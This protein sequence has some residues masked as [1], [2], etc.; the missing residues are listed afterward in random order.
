MDRALKEIRTADPAAIIFLY[1]DHGPWTSR[2]VKFANDN[3]FFVEDRFGTLGAVINADRCLPFLAPPPGEHFQTIA[4]TVVGL[5]QCLA[6]G[7]SPLTQSV[8]YGAIRQVGQGAKFE[9]YIYE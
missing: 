7:T 2:Q 8:D 5:V 9:D 3:K 4:R 6:G 1:G